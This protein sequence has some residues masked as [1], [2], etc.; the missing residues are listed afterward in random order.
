[1]QMNIRLI[2]S[3]RTCYHETGTYITNSTAFGYVYHERSFLVS[4][5][6]RWITE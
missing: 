4:Q 6:L 1:M 5:F 3:E 2:G